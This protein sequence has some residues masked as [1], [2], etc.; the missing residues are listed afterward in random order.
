MDKLM[1]DFESMLE[2]LL[3]SDTK[4]PTFVLDSLGTL[5]EGECGEQ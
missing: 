2:I 5:Q 4:H 1:D 3:D